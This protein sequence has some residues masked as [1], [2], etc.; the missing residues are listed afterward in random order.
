MTSETPTDKAHRLLER[1]GIARS[2]DLERAGVTRTQMRRLRERGLIERVARGLYMLPGSARTERHDLAEAARRV[3]QRTQDLG[4]FQC[5]TPGHA[6]AL[7]VTYDLDYLIS[8]QPV[9]L[10]VVYRN[11]RFIAYALR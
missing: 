10:P 3:R 6:R 7:A 11:D 8:D 2:R 4:E 5:L 9:D 1:I